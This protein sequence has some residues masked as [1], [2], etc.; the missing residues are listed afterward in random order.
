MKRINLPQLAGTDAAALLHPLLGAIA[1]RYETPC[2]VY[3]MDQI[4][5]R[6]R[7]LHRAFDDILDISYAVK[8]NPNP[9]LLSRLRG[10]A[11]L[12]DVS[13]AGEISLATAAGWSAEQ[14]SFTGPG[15]TDKELRAAASQRIGYVVLESVEEAERLH[16][17]VPA[18]HGESPQS[19]L[20]RLALARP[21][22]PASEQALRIPDK[23][24]IAESCFHDALE[25]IARLPRLC[26][27][28]F[29]TYQGGQFCDAGQIAEN[30]GRFLRA[31]VPAVSRFRLRPEL[32]V[33]GAGLGIPYTVAAEPVDLPALARHLRPMLVELRGSMASRRRGS[34]WR[35]A[36][37]LLARPVVI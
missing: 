6:I 28:G 27:R 33:L 7:M 34:C 29:H 19:V 26:L 10:H 9:A 24:G 11:E 36:A 15:K 8:S 16:H 37:I 30:M 20:V 4:H 31:C 14:L 23:F 32:L 25:Q 3:F 21:A 35:P 17:H 1:E 18:G 5:D 22:P 12:L 2:Y 13:S